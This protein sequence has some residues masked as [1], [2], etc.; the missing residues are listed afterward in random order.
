V[1]EKLGYVIRDDRRTRAGDQEAL[2]GRGRL[3]R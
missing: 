2:L 3:P 1:G